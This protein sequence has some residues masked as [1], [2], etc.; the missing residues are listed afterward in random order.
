M[1]SGVLWI[2]LYNELTVTYSV[3]EWVDTALALIKA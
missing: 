1:R 2:V 3:N